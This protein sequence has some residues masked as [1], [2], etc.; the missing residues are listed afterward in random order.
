[1]IDKKD[2]RVAIIKEWID[3]LYQAGRNT[4]I[5]DKEMLKGIQ[6]LEPSL[7]PAKK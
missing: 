6:E 4:S 2:A 7:I 1:M 3:T 5:S